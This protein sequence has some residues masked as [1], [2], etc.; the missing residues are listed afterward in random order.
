MASKPNSLKR[1]DL[2]A[3][4]WTFGDLFLGFLLTFLSSYVV[5]AFEESGT[6][7]HAFVALALSLVI[8]AVRKFKLDTRPTPQDKVDIDAAGTK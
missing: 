5:P 6:G 2:V 1:L 8:Q 4:L 7:I 3:L